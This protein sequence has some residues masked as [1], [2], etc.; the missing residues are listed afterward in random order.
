MGRRSRPGRNRVEHGQPR[1]VELALG[2]VRLPAKEILK[3][4]RASGQPA[5][6]TAE[7]VHDAAEASVAPVGIE[8][9]TD[10][11]ASVAPSFGR[12]WIRM[13]ACDGGDFK[14]ANEPDALD[15][16]GCAF[17][18]VVEA[19]SPQAITSGS[20]RR[21]SRLARAASSASAELWG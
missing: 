13:G 7:A 17:V 8:V 9:R 2:Y 18:V 6:A 19:I 10:G 15:I 21:L 4:G 1:R 16:V 3:R 14:L 11:P 12:Q 20:A 5:P